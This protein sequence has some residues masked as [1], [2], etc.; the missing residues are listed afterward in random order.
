MPC[1]H[2]LVGFAPVGFSILVYVR[3]FVAG[4]TAVTDTVYFCV[5]CVVQL[6]TLVSLSSTMLVFMDD[7]VRAYNYITRL[8]Q[9]DTVFTG[10][11][12]SSVT[13]QLH[14]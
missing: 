7:T 4:D 3:T 1:S 2:I 8:G 5:S 12:G 10:V 6:Y 14:H 9:M 11:R 13:D